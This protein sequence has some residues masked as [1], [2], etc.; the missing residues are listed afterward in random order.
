MAPTAGFYQGY[1]Y[2]RAIEFVGWLSEVVHTRGAWRN[3]G[4]IEVVNEP[5]QNAGAVPGLLDNYYPNAY[6]EVRRR[7]AT[8]G[9]TQNNLLHIQAMVRLV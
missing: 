5:V 3:V 1:Q 6:A 9:I 2:D 7:E 8:L 4:M